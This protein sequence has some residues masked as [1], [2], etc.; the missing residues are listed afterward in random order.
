[1]PLNWDCLVMSAVFLTARSAGRRSG[2]IP[3]MTGEVL[4]RLLAFRSASI[5]LSS[6]P[7]P[8]TRSAA[9]YRHGRRLGHALLSDQPIMRGHEDD[10]FLCKSRP[11][12]RLLIRRGVCRLSP[13]ARPGSEPKQC[14]QGLQAR[15]LP[16]GAAAECCSQGD[17]GRRQDEHEQ[18]DA[19]CGRER[20]RCGVPADCK[21][22]Q[23]G[24]GPP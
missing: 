8:S 21:R 2:A 24:A 19:C 15:L 20:C 7:V 13:S 5:C 9:W 22:Y 23:R 16:G 1:M 17:C 11:D 18:G 12:R 10:G 4:A 3:A 14:L 6:A